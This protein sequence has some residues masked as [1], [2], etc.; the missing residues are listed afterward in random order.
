[1]KSLAK[2]VVVCC[3]L[4]LSSE[5]SLAETIS[6]EGQARVLSLLVNI[7]MQ[8]SKHFS[9]DRLL[10]DQYAVASA[11]IG[12]NLIGEKAFNKLADRELARRD[13][14]VRATGL[15]MW[16]T[17]QRPNLNELGLKAFLD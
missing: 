17:Y 8:C 10:V 1:M 12:Q 7:Q 4:M 9:I 15:K 14:E 5:Q 2:P 6:A 13:K 3:A 16:C 11:R